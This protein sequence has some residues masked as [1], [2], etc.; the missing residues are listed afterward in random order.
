MSASNVEND[1]E[2]GVVAITVLMA[3]CFITFIVASVMP[4][5]GL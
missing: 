3:I 5:F 1:G 4:M 2:P